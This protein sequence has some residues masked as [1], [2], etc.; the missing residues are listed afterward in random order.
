MSEEMKCKNCKYHYIEELTFDYPQSCCRKRS[1]TTEQWCKCNDFEY[2][3]RYIEQLQQENTQLKQENQQL[4]DKMNFSYHIRNDTTSIPAVVRKANDVE[5]IKKLQQE[6]AQLKK[7]VDMYENPEDLTLMFMYCDEKA[8]DKIKHLESEKDDFIKTIIELQY[9]I[10]DLKSVL[11]EIREFCDYL[12]NNDKVSI[13]GKVYYKT[14]DDD[15]V[16]KKLL[17][18]INKGIGEDK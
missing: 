4:K 17:E 10:V 11:K 15:I 2:G 16:T 1:A 3:D 18:I 14:F 8:K 9:E 13:N 6:N 7:R 12:L 5:V